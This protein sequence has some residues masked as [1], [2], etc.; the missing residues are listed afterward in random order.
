[1]MTAWTMAM[2]LIF[3]LALVF[4]CKL[5][6]RHYP[7]LGV[8][9]LLLMLGTMMPP[10]FSMPAFNLCAVSILLLAACVFAVWYLV[11]AWREPPQVAVERRRA[12][13][14]ELDE[15][16]MTRTLH[17]VERDRAAA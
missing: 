13:V 16:D 3:A 17:S 2:L 9:D 14:C 11:K 5:D 7:T 10:V 4:A 6:W 1:M 15:N 8:V 12:R